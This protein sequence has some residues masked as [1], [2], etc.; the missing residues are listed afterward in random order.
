MLDWSGQALACRRPTYEWAWSRR[1]SNRAHKAM[2]GNIGGPAKVLAANVTSLP[3]AWK[4]LRLEEADLYIFQE[5]RMD[6]AGLRKLAADAGYQ[7]VY[8]AEV[9]GEIL[10]AVM[11]RQGSLTKLG[12]CPSGLAHHCRWQMGGQHLVIHNGYYQGGTQGERDA[13]EQVLTE[14]LEAAELSG[15]PTLIAGDFNATQTELPVSRWFAAA[16]WQELGGLQQP[17]TCLPSRGQPRRIDWLLASRGLLPTIHGLAA[18]RWDIGVKPHAVQTV[19]VHLTETRRYPKWHRATPLAT[20]LAERPVAGP[21]VSGRIPP[22]DL[23]IK[24]QLSQRPAG[25]QGASAAAAAVAAAQAAAAAAEAAASSV[26]GL[27]VSGRIPPIDLA[28][29]VQQHRIE[30][31]RPGTRPQGSAAEQAKQ[32]K[33]ARQAE[34]GYWCAQAWSARHTQWQRAK[35]SGSVEAVWEVFWQTTL[36]LHE[37]A[38]GG[39][40]EPWQPGY[41]RSEQEMPPAKAGKTADRAEGLLIRRIG[42]LESLGRVA[43]DTGAA[44]AVIRRQLVRKLRADVQCPQVP[45]VSANLL[46]PWVRRALIGQ[47][48]LALEQHRIAAAVRRRDGWH[49]WLAEQ[50]AA[51]DRKTFAWI[52]ADDATWAPSGTSKAEQLETADACWWELWGKAMAAEA[53]A[54]ALQE[55]PAGPAMPAMQPLTGWQLRGAGLSMG[56]KAGGAD[57][58]QTADWRHWPMQHWN[59]L[60]EVVALCERL[61]RWPQQ[62]LQAHVA[63][64]PKGGKPVAGLQ[65]RPITVLPL[66]YRAWGK[67]RAKQL[68]VGFEAVTDLL[69]GSRQ[70]AEF[71]AAILA[72]TLSLGRATG[73]GAGAAAID[74]VK[75]YDSLELEFLEA[76]LRKAGVP[77]LI[78]GPCFAMYRAERAVRIGDAVGP[79]RLPQSGLPAGC[80]FATLF[81]AVLTGKWRILRDLPSQPSVRSWVDDCTAFVQGREAAVNLAEEA[82]RTAEGMQMMRLMVN[83][84]KSGVRGSDAR[85]TAAMRAVAG[86]QLAGHKVLKDLGVIQ[87]SGAAETEAAMSRWSTACDRMA[88]IARLAVPMLAKG[89]FVAAAAMSV[90]AYGASCREQPDAVMDCMRRWVR[91]AVWSGGPAADYRVLLWSG[92]IP[93]RADP[94]VA[95]LWAAARTVSLLVKDGHFSTAQLGWLWSSTDR[96][97]PVAALRRALLRAGV[98]G[99]LHCWRSGREALEQPLFAEAQ[100]REAW[101]QRAQCRCDMAKV[102]A[103]RP[104]LRLG[105]H[106][107]QWGWIRGQ[108]ARLHLSADR[109]AALIGVMAGDAVPE[110]TAMKWTKGTGLCSCG[111]PEDLHHRWWRCPRRHALRRQALRGAK[112]AAIAALPQC[113]VL[114]GIPVELPAVARWREGLP[115][116]VPV[117][118]PSSRRYYPDG[119]CLRPRLPEVRVAAWAVVGCANGVWWYRAGPCP[120]EQT[121]GRAELAAIVQILNGAE[122]GVILTDC[123]GVQRKC[124]SIQCGS[125]TREEL[126]KGT[127]A[128]LWA[129][130]WEPLRFQKGWTVEWL[131]SH[132]SLPEALAAGVSQEDWHGND[133]AD[134]AAKA[135]ARRHDLPAEVLEQ[136]ADRQAANEAVWR[137]IAESQVAHLSARPRRHDGAAAKVRKRKA[138]ARPNRR[139]RARVAAGAVEPPAPARLPQSVHARATAAA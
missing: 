27:A 76:A 33:K 10:V 53:R 78:L 72:T 15:E 6:A 80:P 125:I 118:M 67:A 37:A 97:N 39:G 120:G 41:T 91:H 88:R 106:A 121:I 45:P 24:A 111:E 90:G 103:G 3:G 117:Q 58:L 32:Q 1:A 56:E 81:M 55:M 101:L 83:L 122:P 47:T 85:L 82:G 50:K 133:L 60:A 40:Q 71:Q 130:V 61:G 13:S 7:V 63:L 93:V 9:E 5:V 54:A 66:V 79:A 139:V 74:F 84:D 59:M 49:A 22:I 65:A 136:W 18:V 104:K 14:W 89:R 114:Y 28:H 123:E 36:D 64:L 99:D 112:P 116:D 2:H 137:L 119:S 30:G 29:G 73:E 127:N 12:A 23:A 68:K 17:V 34:V 87:G 109:L 134:A 62:L 26:A 42:Q 4:G 70:E 138:P 113:T 35:R 100:V 115:A 95:V 48:K 94:V 25:G 98:A 132:R 110:Q 16:G 108:V 86:P 102:A 77:Q 38:G 135:E 57:G 21:A 105:E 92:C 52:R 129:R 124:A 96:C 51:G 131:P 69:V 20:L 128:D 43:M 44:Q 31:L 126:G 46:D 8:G 19:K 11:A 75:A 107:I